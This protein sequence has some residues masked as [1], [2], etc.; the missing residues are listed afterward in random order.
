MLKFTIKSR[1]KDTKSSSIEALSFLQL[2]SPKSTKKECFD[3]FFWFWTIFC[4]L[5]GKNGVFVWGKITGELWGEKR[6]NYEVKNGLFMGQKTGD[7]W[8]EMKGEKMEN[9]EWRMKNEEWRM[10][11]EEWRM[12]NEEWRDNKY[13]RVHTYIN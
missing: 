1:P 9:E 3:G 4:A 8:G 6:V 12:E 7:L 11:N 2:F 10:K 13:S 5:K